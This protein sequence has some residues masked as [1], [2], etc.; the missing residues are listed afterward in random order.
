MSPT[1]TAADVKTPL[2]PNSFQP[3]VEPLK[4][5][6][7]LNE[8]SSPGRVVQ[9]LVPSRLSKVAPSTVALPSPLPSGQY[10]VPFVM[11]MGRLAAVPLPSLRR[12]RLAPETVMAPKVVCGGILNWMMY[13]LYVLAPPLSSLTVWSGVAPKL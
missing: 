4:V 12:K 10:S 8:P 6:N 5:A 2:R 7:D 3:A 9:L 13:R 1:M 11:V